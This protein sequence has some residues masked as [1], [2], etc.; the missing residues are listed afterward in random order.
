[1][2]IEATEVP[3]CVN[4]KHYTPHPQYADAKDS[5]L[6]E[7]AAMCGRTAQPNPVSG[8]IEMRTCISE[9]T[10]VGN[11]FCGPAAVFYEEES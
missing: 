9:R 4:C 10:I 8:R 3:L 5:R 7:G 6:Q 1:M 11:D 2:T